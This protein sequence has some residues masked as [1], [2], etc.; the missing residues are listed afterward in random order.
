MKKLRHC[1]PMYTVEGPHYILLLLLLLMLLLLLLH[2]SNGCV[3]GLHSLTQSQCIRPQISIDHVRLRLLVLH[4][5]E[6]RP[7]VCRLSVLR[8]LKFSA[9]FL[10]HLVTWPSLDVHEKFYGDRPREPLR[11][12]VKHKMGS[13]IKQFR[14]YRRL[15]L[16]NSAR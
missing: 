2:I 4:F 16:G 10:R 1:H 3:K 8:R 15:Y 6:R 12:E 7:S 13:Q 14:T 5:S 11:R 9:I